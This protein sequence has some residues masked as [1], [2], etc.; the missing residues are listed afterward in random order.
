M[1]VPSTTHVES[2]NLDATIVAP[3]PVMDAESPGV[4]G[5]RH[6][7]VLEVPLGQRRAHVRAEI[8]DRKEL[9]AVIEDGNHAS[10]DF[11]PRAVPFRNLICFCYCRII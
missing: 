1:S 5:A 3:G 10:G 6:D 4:P 9:A 8:V 11:E 7:T 2:V